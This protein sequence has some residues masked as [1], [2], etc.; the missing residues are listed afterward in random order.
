[1][2]PTTVQFSGLDIN[3]RDVLQT[4]RHHGPYPANWTRVQFAV[5][6]ANINS[7]VVNWMVEHINGRW[8]GYTR[9]STVVLFFEDATDAIMFRLQGG[10]ETFSSEF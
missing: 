8:G 3:P 1:M 10:E 7:K 2:I 9:T 6:Y 5:Q 4:K